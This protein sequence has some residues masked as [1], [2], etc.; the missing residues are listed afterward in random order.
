VNQREFVK[1]LVNRAV[2]AASRGTIAQLQSPS[3]RSPPP[4]L[5]RLSK[6]YHGLDDISK[7]AVEEVVGRA[8]YAATFDFLCIL[9]GA[10]A[11]VD[12]GSNFQLT[13]IAPYGSYMLKPGEDDLHDLFS[14]IA[15]K[16]LA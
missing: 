8:A 11:V 2:L 16:D 6:W 12:G 13:L 15:P 9:D 4:H 14:E 10:A 1:V 3:G 5:V 7:K